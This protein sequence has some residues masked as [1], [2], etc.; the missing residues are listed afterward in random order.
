[1]NNFYIFSFIGL[2]TLGGCSEC[3]E[4]GN[5]NSCLKYAV[6]YINMVTYRDIFYPD[7]VNPFERGTS[8]EELKSI[9]INPKFTKNE[10]KE[11]T[12]DAWGKSFIVKEIV[13]TQQG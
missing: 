2:I 3:I 7:I 5:E 8:E 12:K 6:T 11:R 9:H 4:T 13:T 10:V 1:M